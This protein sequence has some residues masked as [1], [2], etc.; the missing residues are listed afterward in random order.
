MVLL[1]QPV[2]GIL[3][4]C[5][6]WDVTEIFNYIIN[7]LL[8]TKSLNLLPLTHQ[9]FLKH[10]VSDIATEAAK[11][12]INQCQLV[13]VIQMYSQRAFALFQFSLYPSYALVQVVCFVHLREMQFRRVLKRSVSKVKINNY[14]K[15]TLSGNFA[16]AFYL[17]L[18]MNQ[19]TPQK[20]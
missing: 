2:T 15:K 1:A 8:W 10:C 14:V 18:I 4:G 13:F 5:Q 20:T 12:W 3:T 9:L 6:I 19:K 16:V 7:G 17:H 11:S